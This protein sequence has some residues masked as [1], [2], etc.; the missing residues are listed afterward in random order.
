MHAMFEKRKY[1]NVQFNLRLWVAK[2]AISFYSV[3]TFRN[4]AICKHKIE[5]KKNLNKYR[6]GKMYQLNQISKETFLS[7][8]CNNWPFVHQVWRLCYFY[9]MCLQCLHKIERGK[10]THT[11]IYFTYV[12]FSIR[13]AGQNV[14][15]MLYD[16]HLLL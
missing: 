4:Y 15:T 5:E 1:E 7:N 8:R 2:F 11:H 9:T 14:I 3:H 10:N 13:V 16:L 12:S 6:K